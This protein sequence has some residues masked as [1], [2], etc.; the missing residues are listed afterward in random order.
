MYVSIFIFLQMSTMSRP[1]VV[2]GSGAA[3]LAAACCLLERDPSLRVLLLEADTRIGGR[4]QT[5]RIGAA[6]AESG[7]AWLHGG[8]WPRDAEAEDNSSPLARW[9][10]H[11]VGSEGT[12]FTDCGVRPVGRH[13]PWSAASPNP[14]VHV[15]LD[16]WTFI[17]PAL[18][19]TGGSGSAAA[20]LSK[21]LS[22]ALQRWYDESAAE[23]TA[24]E[25]S[26]DDESGCDEGDGDEK[27][28]T[29]GPALRLARALSATQS[30]A[31][32]VDGARTPSDDRADLAC[33]VRELA[34]YILGC[35]FGWQLD[36]VQEDDATCSVA[37]DD[38]R[39]DLPGPH[40][41]VVSLPQGKDGSEAGCC[42]ICCH[43]AC[44]AAAAGG[45]TAASTGAGGVKPSAVD[46]CSL[47]QC[48]RIRSLVGP[49]CEGGMGR[50]IA[51]MLVSCV[52]AGLRQESGDACAAS[53]SSADDDC[54]S[55]F[56]AI[57]A[58]LVA[59]RFTLATDCRVTAVDYSC[60][61]VDDDAG[62]DSSAVRIM[63]VPAAAAAGAIGG[64]HP[65]SDTAAA[66]AGGGA[67]TTVSAS[68]VIV[69]VP[70]NVLLASSDAA[71]SSP[72][73]SSVSLLPASL[74]EIRFSPP[75]PAP[76]VAALRSIRSGQYKK[77][78]IAFESSPLP[79]C[80]TPF[81]A[82]LP[83]AAV[84]AGADACGRCCFIAEAVG[85]GAGGPLVAPSGS[86]RGPRFRIV[87]NGAVIKGA[88][89]TTLSG[90]L[91]GDELQRCRCCGSGTAEAAASNAGASSSS[92]SASTWSADE[93]VSALLGQL[94]DAVRVAGWP[95]L[96]RVTETQVTAWESSPLTGCGAYSFIPRGV[97]DVEALQRDLQTP[98]LPSPAT[99]ATSFAAGGSGAA[100]SSKVASLPRVF[101]AGEAL[102][103]DFM[104]S[105]HGAVLSGQAAAKK[106][107]RAAAKRK[108]LGGAVA[109]V[110]AEK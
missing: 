88:S 109:T 16:T 62:I 36:Q 2:I 46:C 37:V 67:A 66:T 13:E 40:L 77:V 59:G 28:A 44:D 72:G 41:S 58:A 22:E 80:S 7:A 95:P 57:P 97:E 9:M 32:G 20:E 26:G 78:H 93:C 48:D 75:L 76:L 42:A 105:L 100:S 70:A 51:R 86:R 110:A 65:S 6:Y 71:S 24:H 38:C 104:G 19:T 11:R 99:D 35:W 83:P 84:A 60:A 63:M 102:H 1:A 49:G 21:R 64:G 33:R 30:S 12:G 103:C 89:Y 91:Y 56:A 39:G 55:P 107:L 73:V 68:D 96:P 98:V 31:A 54:A 23:A 106:A 18:E 45:I 14:W 92:S 79:A 94:N 27:A 52:A 29:D 17:E 101:L 82:L 25:E 15:G 81:V 61:E 3:G 5:K 10:M 47:L 90:I 87:E 69:A 50:L 43:V 53:D 8:C 74:P 4:V 108:A 34:R 85:G